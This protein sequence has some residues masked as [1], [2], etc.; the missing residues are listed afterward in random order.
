MRVSDRQQKLSETCVGF[1]PTPRAINLV[2]DL[3]HAG[4][5]HD[6]KTRH[7]DSAIT[8]HPDEGLGLMF[9]PRWCAITDCL[10]PV[11]GQLCFSWC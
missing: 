4:F 11:P 10:D 2:L 9:G 3:Q 1:A 7:P 5:C 8:S 6:P